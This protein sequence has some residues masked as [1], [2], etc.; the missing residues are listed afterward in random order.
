MSL[1]WKISAFSAAIVLLAVAGFGG[2]AY[3]SEGRALVKARRDRNLQAAA[4]LGEVCRDALIGGQILGLSNYLKKM[5]GAPDVS[6]AWCAD[7]A[8][9]LLGHTDIALTHGMLSPAEAERARGASAT[10]LREDGTAVEALA[11][12]FVAGR[13]AATAAIFFSAPE[14]RRRFEEDM[15]AARRRL[16]PLAGAALA[17]GF[18]GAFLLTAL[19]L[20]PL[21]ALVEGV[22]TVARGKL[23]HVI[24]VPARDEVGWLAR[25]FNEMAAKLQE[26]DRMK[27]DFVNG[28]THDLKSPLATVKVSLDL[29]QG[30][31]DAG[32]ADPRLLAEQVFTV[33][34]SMERLTHMITSL[35]EVAHIEQGLRL[36]KSPAGLDD[37]ADRAVKSLALVAR[38]K[39]LSLDLVVDTALSPLPMDTGKVE[40][41][42]VNLVSNAVKYTDRGS[43][44]VSVG[45]EGGRQ[46]VRVKDTGP[47]IP[48]EALDRLFTKFFR[49]ARDGKKEGTGLG[50]AVVKGIAEA[51][52][53]GVSVESRAG[54]GS[55]FT[56]WLPGAG[57]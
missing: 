36:D 40:R 57:A 50:L 41:A 16:A 54:E 9:E 32:R 42:L 20:R 26:L 2:A 5:K 19:V 37:V 8:G 13:R 39:G 7:E 51:H 25:E 3:W 14:M 1:K 4:A 52:G 11:P 22:R 44:T 53:G 18:A 56:F 6:A 31:A 34:Q 10:S 49:I 55:A 27:Q 24:S 45:A 43:V 17:G 29:L 30:E 48:P 38:Q 47:G 35:L 15:A 23:D 28:V 33:R 46:Y 21:G 12:V